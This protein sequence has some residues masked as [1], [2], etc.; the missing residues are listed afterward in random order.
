MAR[1]GEIDDDIHTDVRV[2]AA[3]NQLEIPEA[4][5]R[6]LQNGLVEEEEMDKSTHDKLQLFAESNGL[7][8]IQAVRVLLNSTLDEDGSLKKGTVIKNV[9]IEQVSK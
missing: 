2:Y 4:Y 8:K 7:N 9:S 1:P 6:L 3:K 5:E